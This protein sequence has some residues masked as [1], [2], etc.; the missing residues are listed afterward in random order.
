MF[1]GEPAPRPRKNERPHG[2]RPRTQT[3]GV[4]EVRQ[5]LRACPWAALYDAE[6]RVYG[7][8]PR[9]NGLRESLSEHNSTEGTRDWALEDMVHAERASIQ[10]PVAPKPRRVR[11]LKQE[12][13]K[14]E[15]E[16]EEVSSAA[17]SLMRVRVKKEEEE[18]EKVLP[19]KRPFAPTPSPGRA[20]PFA[21][22]AAHELQPPS[23]LPSGK[24]VLWVWLTSQGTSV[25][26][27]F[28]ICR[29]IGTCHRTLR[30]SYCIRTCP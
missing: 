13:K 10:R 2:T 23:F 22:G 26:S 24:H 28:F 15:E 17:E 30:L 14:E 25:A 16:E 5:I 29:D 19:S 4:P 8:L 21:P 20:P 18:P 7:W 1:T 6:G 11:L 27:T 9:A 3:P 12:A